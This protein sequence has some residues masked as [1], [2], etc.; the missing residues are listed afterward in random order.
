MFSNPKF[1]DFKVFPAEKP[2]RIALVGGLKPPQN[3]NVLYTVTF[4]YFGNSGEAAWLKSDHSINCRVIRYEHMY[5]S[6]I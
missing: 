6:Y 5:I 4:I 3:N 1:M 2:A